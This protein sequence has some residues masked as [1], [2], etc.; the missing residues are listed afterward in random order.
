MHW[1]L[2]LISI[3]FSLGKIDTVGMSP[4]IRVVEVI[5]RSIFD[6]VEEPQALPKVV[7]GVL[8]S[9]HEDLPDTPC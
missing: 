1:P 2:V 4:E 6:A 3:G 5:Q 9:S 7:I 8:R